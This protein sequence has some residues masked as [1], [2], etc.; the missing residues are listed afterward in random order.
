MY[1]QRRSCPQSKYLYKR[2]NRVSVSAHSAGAYTATFLV[3]VNVIKGGGRAPHTLNRPGKVYPHDW[4][5]A[6]KQTLLLCGLVCVLESL[7]CGSVYEDWSTVHTDKTENKIFLVY[8]E[9]QSGAVAKPYFSYMTNGL[10]IYDFATAPLTISLYMWKI[11]FSFLSVHIL[12]S[13]TALPPRGN[14]MKVKFHVWST[15]NYSPS[16]LHAPPP[17]SVMDVYT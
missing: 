6:R 10:L 2:W 11:L 8:K 12:Y 14:G 15:R 16:L 4:M 1:I 17:P 3:M 5:Y 13:R 7:L 9:I